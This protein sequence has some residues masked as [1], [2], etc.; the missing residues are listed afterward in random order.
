[1]SIWSPSQELVILTANPV[2]SATTYTS[3]DAMG[4]DFALANAVGSTKFGGGGLIE[5]VRVADQEANALPIDVL[6]FN[7]EPADSTFDDDD[8]AVVHA[9]DTEKLIDVVELTTW[10]TQTQSW[11]RAR[12]L[13]IP[14]VLSPGS[15]SLW[16]ALIARGAHVLATTTDIHLQV[17]VLKI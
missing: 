14:F 2:V 11:A 16:C 6:F 3:G 9:N 10:Y 1:M 17:A 5:H 7:A 8:A 15:S 12:N 4:P 13:A